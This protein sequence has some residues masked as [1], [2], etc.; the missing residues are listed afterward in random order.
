MLPSN[1]EA[2]FAVGLPLLPDILG[3]LLLEVL[4]SLSPGGH[5]FYL[6]FSL[7]LFNRSVNNDFKMLKI[8]KCLTRWK[9]FY[10]NTLYGDAEGREE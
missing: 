4:I 5:Q 2:A 3:T 1:L 7:L 9:G 6:P 10:F 8:G